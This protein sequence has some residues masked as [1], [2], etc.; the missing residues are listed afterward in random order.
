[1]RLLVHIHCVMGDT[2]VVVELA[3]LNSS[4]QR[5]TNMTSEATMEWDTPMRS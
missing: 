5:P 2:L 3:H 4:L 1:M